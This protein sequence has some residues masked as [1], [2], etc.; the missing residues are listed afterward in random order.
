MIFYSYR[1]KLD[2]QITFLAIISYTVAGM[3]RN[4]GKEEYINFKFFYIYTI[5]LIWLSKYLS[6]FYN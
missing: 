1:D 5:S 6:F 3:N 2:A 4:A